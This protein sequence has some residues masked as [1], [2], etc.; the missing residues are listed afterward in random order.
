MIHPCGTPVILASASPRRKELLEGLGL[1]F[2]CVPAGLPETLRPGE[3]PVEHA[4]RLAREKARHVDVLHPGATVISA[5]TIVVYR[6][7]ILGKP[8]DT[9]DAFRMLKMLSGDT[10]RVITAFAVVNRD[11]GIDI[12]EHSSTA[13]TFRPLEEREIRGYIES[14]S[15]MDKAGGYGIQDLKANFV[16]AIRGCF[17]NI[18]GFPVA[19]FTQQW[20]NIFPL[21]KKKP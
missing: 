20:N 16:K 4:R 7:H 6:H 2:S 11:H 3:G 9:G 5:D 15:P 12:L 19:D 10:H 13:V 14:G 17:Y 8:Q 18:I 1:E 21:P